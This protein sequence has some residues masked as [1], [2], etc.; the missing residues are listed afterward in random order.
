M[1]RRSLL[2]QW[3]LLYP[4]KVI[5]QQTSSRVQL[6]GSE[7]HKFAFSNIPRKWKKLAQVLAGSNLPFTWVANSLKH[8]AIKLSTHYEFHRYHWRLSN[9]LLFENKVRP[10]VRGENF[11]LDD[12]FK[13]AWIIY[14]RR[15]RHEESNVENKWQHYWILRQE[16]LELF[17]R[18]VKFM[19]VK[20]TFL[21][22]FYF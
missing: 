9:L 8:F 15:W 16:F 1:R 7:K 18:N 17:A 4:A 3:E 21:M 11:Y 19:H 6:I 12:D 14:E 20:Q 5:F 13:T 10:R 22:M 2:E